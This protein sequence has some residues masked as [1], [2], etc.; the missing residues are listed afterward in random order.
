MLLYHVLY[1]KA[2]KKKQ[3][4]RMLGTM[5]QKLLKHRVILI[6]DTKSIIHRV[7]QIIFEATSPEGIFVKE[8]NK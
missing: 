3:N 1:F 5:R 2:D 6:I 7:S 4:T 8:Q